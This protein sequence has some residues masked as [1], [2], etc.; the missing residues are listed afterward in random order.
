MN[1]YLIISAL[2]GLSSVFLGSYSEH[3][4]RDTVSEEMIRKFMVGVR[5]HQNYSI[6]LLILSLL[7]YLPIPEALIGKFNIAFCI[8]LFATI[9][10]CGSVYLFVISN[11]KL[12]SYIAPIGGISLMLAWI[13]LV[14]IAFTKV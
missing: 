11:S 1:I 5:Y 9:T 10:F 8:F 14:Y 12:I 6:I 4:L 7:N 2:V 3:T 13:Y